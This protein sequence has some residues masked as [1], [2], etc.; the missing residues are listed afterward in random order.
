MKAS[1][2]RARRAAIYC[3][4]STDEQWQG[5]DFNTLE[6]QA[7][8]CKHAVAMKEPDG[9]SLGRIYEDGGYSGG[10]TDRPALKELIA[11][12]EA[13]HIHAVVVYRLDRLTRSI[14]D[15]YE[16][17]QIFERHGVVFVSATEAFSTDTPT[18]ELFLNLILSL[19][20]WERGLTRQRVSDKIAERSKRGLWNGGNAPFGYSYSKE[21]KLLE[22]H[23]TETSIVR[24][25]FG[26]IAAGVAPVEV[27]RLLNKNGVRTKQRLETRKDGSSVETGGKRWV[28]QNVSRMVRNALY[29]GVIVHDEAEYPGRHQ[30]L[31]DDELWK[32]ANK[33]L[34][35][36]VKLPD[37]ADA[38][39][40]Q[41]NRHQMLL[42]GILRCGHCG[43]HLIPKP[44]GKKDKD[45][46]PYLYYVCGDLNK[47]GKSDGCVLR[48]LPARG[49][50]EYLIQ[51]MGELGKHP[52]I[53]RA[54]TEASRKDYEEAAKPF[55]RKLREVEKDLDSVS[56]EVARLIGMAKRPELKGLSN[57]FIEEANAAGKRKAELQDER[58]KLKMEI[59]YRRNL[60]TDEE[61]ICG[62]LLEFTSLFEELTFEEQAELIGLLFKDIRVTRFDPEKDELPC[63]KEAFVTQMRT[64]WYRVDLR[65]FSNRLSI[66]EM[67]GKPDSLPGV[68]NKA[69]DGGQRGIRTLGDIAATHAFQAC[70]FDHSD[71]CPWRA[72]N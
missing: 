8:I 41:R 64:S 32:A 6:S 17:N 26:Q 5:K 51:L 50:E 1:E 49:F 16:L 61:I 45:G 63:E 3:R 55:E 22:P 34:T 58:E 42:K 10:S 15:F 31:V 71:I 20:Q 11:D 68:R 2:K 23:A 24:D 4:C 37:N 44:A 46:N 38:N 65:M 12:I 39:L 19:A 29:R 25:I 72:G 47:H 56:E 67:L 7:S 27:A 9:W 35:A 28:G 14:A 70:S 66:S 13:G 48:N 43:K 53:I 62:K 57:E 36:G 69:M 54:T 40:R 30:A 52:E 33:V 60:V 18:G 59:D 21:T